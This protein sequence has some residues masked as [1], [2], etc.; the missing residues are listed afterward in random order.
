M[1]DKVYN[2]DMKKKLT[3][4]FNNN[5][6]TL[7]LFSQNVESVKICQIPE[8]GDPLS[9]RE[10]LSVRKAPLRFFQMIPG[11]ILRQESFFRQ[12]CN[13]LKLASSVVKT[14]GKEIRKNPSKIISSI[15]IEITT[16]KMEEEEAAK[17]HWIVASCVGT[18]DALEMA[19]TDG[20][21]RH[22][23]MPCGAVAAKLSLEGQEDFFPEQVDGEAFCFLPLSLP[24]RFEFIFNVDSFTIIFWSIVR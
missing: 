16:K 4:D 12:Q 7:L 19:L 8:N 22:G 24:N 10:I 23:L 13:V 20:G 17:D 6:A 1:S 5:A 18:S 21:R 3:D 2:D 11:G 9:M 14:T 15:L